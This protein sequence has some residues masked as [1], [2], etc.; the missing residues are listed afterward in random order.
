MFSIG[1]PN[2]FRY[3]ILMA[4]S[5]FRHP[6]FE[7]LKN[8]RAITLEDQSIEIC[9]TNKIEKYDQAVNSI[10]KALDFIEVGWSQSLLTD[11]S[12]VSDFMLTEKEINWLTFELGVEIKEDDLFCDIAKRIYE[13]HT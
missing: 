6:Y 4:I 11:E 7:E 10:L 1:L 12:M 9:S 3:F 13:K 8:L 2:S 5:N